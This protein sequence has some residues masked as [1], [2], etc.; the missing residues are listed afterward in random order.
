M[1]NS[2]KSGF[3]RLYQE[4]KRRR[5]IRVATLY[6]VL[7]W[8]IIQ[9]ADI[10]SPALSI[11]P[12]AM[13]YLLVVFVVGFPFVL[14]LSWLFDLNSDPTE[15]TNL[16]AREGERVAGLKAR[17]AAHNAEQREPAWPSVG[18]FPVNVDK[19]LLDHDAPDDEYIYWPN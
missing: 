6:V 15:Q 12:E 10:L 11:P 17:L 5:V 18:E 7:F 8:P 3:Q 2:E 19:T 16:A 14:M 9:V 1:A 4:L 13:R